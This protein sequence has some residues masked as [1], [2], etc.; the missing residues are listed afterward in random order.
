MILHSVKKCLIHSAA[1]SGGALIQRRI[2]FTQTW[3]GS[4]HLEKRAQVLFRE[5][6]ARTPDLRKHGER[7]SVERPEMH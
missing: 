5:P 2:A 6:A 7:V 3:S 4:P 1:E